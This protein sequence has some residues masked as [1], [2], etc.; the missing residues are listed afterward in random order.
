MGFKYAERV[1]EATTNKPATNATPFNLGGARTGYRTAVAGVGSGQRSVFCAQ[2]VDGNGNPSGAW[3]VFVGTVTA[4]TPDTLSRDHLIRSTTGAF[5]DWSASG[6]DSAPDISSVHPAGIG[7]LGHGPLFNNVVSDVWFSPVFLLGDYQSAAV[8]V[9][10]WGSPMIINQPALL[11]GLRCQ[12]TGGAAAGRFVRMGMYRQNGHASEPLE[13]VAAATE[14]ECDTTGIKQDTTLSVFL[15]PGIYWTVMHPSDQNVSF[16]GTGASAGFGE[17]ACRNVLG[18]RGT[19]SLR[20][21]AISGL[22]FNRAYQPLPASFTFND[23]RALDCP[24]V[25]A[26]FA[27][28]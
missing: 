3:E 14:L 7:V 13:L 6:E 5:I 28:P 21:S 25:Q 22:R 24:I 12:V 23:S 26:K 18:V 9:A 4:G 16:A 10:I 1:K 19:S 20:D 15:E 17:N 2:K 8:M 11:V 27:V